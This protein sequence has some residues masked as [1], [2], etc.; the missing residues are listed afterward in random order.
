VLGVA[1]Q[2]L[3]RDREDAASRGQA[4]NDVETELRHH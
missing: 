2:R 1:L 3:E 4:L